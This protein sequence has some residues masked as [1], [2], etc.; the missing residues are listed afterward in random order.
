[1]CVNK[2]NISQLDWNLLV[3]LLRTEAS[4]SLC[5]HP[6][7]CHKTKA[8]QVS[9]FWK[10][11][12]SHPLLH[13]P[14]CSFVSLP[15]SLNKYNLPRSWGAVAKCDG[16]VTKYSVTCSIIFGDKVG[17][18]K[19]DSAGRPAFWVLAQEWLKSL[20]TLPSWQTGMNICGLLG[21]S[22]FKTVTNSI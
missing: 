17:R 22:Y 18:S 2:K 7:W 1:M 8:C 15:L 19:K 16:E 10:P 14:L 5:T 13:L 21:R 9:H 12:V 20:L 6:P 11:F 4:S 3:A